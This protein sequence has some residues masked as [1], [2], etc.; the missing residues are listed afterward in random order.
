LRLKKKRRFEAPKTFSAAA[1]QNRSLRR[2]NIGCRQ[3]SM[4]FGGGKAKSGY[5]GDERRRLK[6]K[7]SRRDKIV[8]NQKKLGPTTTAKQMRLQKI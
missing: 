4:F 1:G 5:F 8:A 3:S 7:T 6:K 2:M